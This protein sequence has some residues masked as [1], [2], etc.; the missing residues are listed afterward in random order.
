ME[1]LRELGLFSLEDKRPKGY[2]I[3]AFQYLRKAYKKDGEQLFTEC[4][5]LRQSKEE[6]DKMNSPCL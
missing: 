5:G 3:V 2:L 1:R 6:H 4:L